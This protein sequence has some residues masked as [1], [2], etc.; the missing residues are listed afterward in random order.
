MN[1]LLSCLLSVALQGVSVDQ[2][3]SIEAS[4][5]NFPKGKVTSELIIQVRDNNSKIKKLSLKE[6]KELLDGSYRE[7][8]RQALFDALHD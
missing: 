6:A 4:I 3:R 5:R 8:M 2:A 1:L 7:I